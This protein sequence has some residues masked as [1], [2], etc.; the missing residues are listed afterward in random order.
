[1][2]YFFIKF[3]SRLNIC[4][5]IGNFKKYLMVQKSIS[6]ISFLIHISILI[7]SALQKAFFD[8]KLQR[9]MKCI[10]NYYLISIILLLQLL[11]QSVFHHIF[12][13]RVWER[14]QGLPSSDRR[15]IASSEFHQAFAKSSKISL[16]LPNFF[17]ISLSSYSAVTAV[18]AV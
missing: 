2:S 9:T 15:A 13:S 11:M 1:M 4:T 16:V 6:T 10:E 17:V 12:I 3:I 7:P 18:T 8:E 5:C 14:C